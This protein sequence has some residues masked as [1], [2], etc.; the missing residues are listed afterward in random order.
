MINVPH[1]LIDEQ[2]EGTNRR[3]GGKVQA[4]DRSSVLRLMPQ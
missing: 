4:A 1:R 2:Y 3:Q